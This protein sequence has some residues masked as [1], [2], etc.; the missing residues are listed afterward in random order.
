MSTWMLILGRVDERLL[1]ALVVRRRSLVSYGM[2]G[3][4][5]LADP[6]VALAIALVLFFI[7]FDAPVGP[8]LPALITLIT[9]HVVVQALKHMAH[10][11]RPDLPRGFRC[12]VDAPDRFSFPSGHAAAALSLALPV[13]AVLSV[14]PSATVILLALL[15]GISRSYLGIHYPGDVLMGWI[16]AA[17]CYAA[18][19]HLLPLHFEP[20]LF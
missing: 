17:G 10:R 7:P 13:A 12:L 3:I 5:R 14:V 19:N 20:V 16:V 6:P 8:A 1:H 11:N 9:S 15:V 4:T 2:A 18:G